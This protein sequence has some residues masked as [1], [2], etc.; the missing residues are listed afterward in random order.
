LGVLIFVWSLAFIAIIVLLLYIAGINPLNFQK[1]KSQAVLEAFTGAGLEVS[2]PAGFGSTNGFGNQVVPFT[3]QD[4]FNFAIPGSGANAT[5]NITSFSTGSELDK[6]KI[7]L[8][9]LA[10]AGTTSYRVFTR[11][12]ILIYLTNVTS[13]VKAKQ[14]EAVL[15]SLK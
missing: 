2:R 9:N 14:Y 3:Y 13:E 5:G 11:D 8:A 10:N 15:L 6:A 7:Y 12:N 4:G 1:Y